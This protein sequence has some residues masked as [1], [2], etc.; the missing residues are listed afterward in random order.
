MTPLLLIAHWQLGA[1]SADTAPAQAAALLAAGYDTPALGEL[2]GLVRP[3]GDEVEAAMGRVAQE[4]G[5]PA[6]TNA[7]AGRVLVREW[8]RQIL[9]G[10]LTAAEGARLIWNVTCAPD[11]P[12]GEYAPFIG[13]AIQYL[14]L[15]DQRT[16][17]DEDMRRAAQEYLG[18]HP[19]PVA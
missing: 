3:D 11:V 5:L 4:F 17:L 1:F 7:S 2:A 18:Q 19:G 14:E 12:P 8:T 13:I 15:T 16:A 9:A 10:E 6:S